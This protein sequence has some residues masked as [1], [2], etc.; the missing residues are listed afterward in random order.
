MIKISTVSDT[1]TEVDETIKIT[2]VIKDDRE[3][4]CSTTVYIVDG[5]K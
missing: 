1:Q 2:A 5:S 3:V 4:T